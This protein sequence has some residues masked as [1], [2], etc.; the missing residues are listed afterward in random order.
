MLAVDAASCGLRRLRVGRTRLGC[1]AQREI[2]VPEVAPVDRV[3]GLEFRRPA[4]V[5]QGVLEPI[6]EI[7]RGAE[8]RSCLGVVLDADRA[9]ES[10]NRIVES[11]LGLVAERYCAGAFELAVFQG[12][13]T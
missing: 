13:N 7:Q 3:V 4:V 9:L 8:V 12:S 11:A 5:L 6:E 1:P 2:G 10:R